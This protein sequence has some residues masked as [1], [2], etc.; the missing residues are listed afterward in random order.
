MQNTTTKGSRPTF[1]GL[2]ISLCDDIPLAVAA[3]A[4][5]DS[6]PSPS[7][8]VNRGWNSSPHQGLQGLGWGLGEALDKNISADMRDLPPLGP[9]GWSL[10]GLLTHVSK[11]E[12]GYVYPNDS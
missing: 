6:A 4:H 7:E 11:S 12:H 2:L 9:R 10:A 5:G 3:E 8:H 1:S